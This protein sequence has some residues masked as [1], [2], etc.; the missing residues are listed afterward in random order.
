ME[1][2]RIGAQII[3]HGAKTDGVDVFPA[4]VEHHVQSGRTH[5]RVQC[6]T[7]RHCSVVVFGEDVMP[8][9]RHGL[10]MQQRLQGPPLHDMRFRLAAKV[11]D[12]TGH[13]V[14]R[15]YQRVAGGAARG[16]RRR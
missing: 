2:V 3:Q 8:P 1:F 7:G 9:I 4:P 16:V 6:P 10:A 13:Q 15:F 5:R 11:A 12:E 14:D